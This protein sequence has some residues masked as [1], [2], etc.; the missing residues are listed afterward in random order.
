M[1]WWK[2]LRRPTKHLIILLPLLLLW[3]FINAG[4]YQ[5]IHN[6]CD[7]EY[8][9]YFQ[10]FGYLMTIAFTIGYGHITPS[11]PGGKV[12]MEKEMSKCK[13]MYQSFHCRSIHSFSHILPFPWS[14]TS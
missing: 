8:I 13:D 6:R 9:T 7:N 1:N 10:S 11:C 12:R 2:E 3:M 4:I 14:S 5:Q